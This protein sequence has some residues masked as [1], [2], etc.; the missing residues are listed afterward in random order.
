MSKAMEPEVVV[1]GGAA[2]FLTTIDAGRHRLI[3]DEPT[4]VGGSDSGPSPYELLLASLGSC[5]SMTLGLYARRK[6]WPLEEV[7]V[8]LRHSKVHAD[9]CADC[10]SKPALLD[11]IEREISLIGALTDEQ[12][13]RLLEI[14]EK[15]P[16][17]R[18]LTSSVDVRTRLIP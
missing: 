18:T 6:G 7:A 8:R 10:E 11:R 1:R 3:A 13:A 17:H 14:A 5:T 2:D 16:V 4:R 9:D 15:C 12:R